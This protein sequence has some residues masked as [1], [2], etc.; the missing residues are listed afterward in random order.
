[1][2][3]EPPFRGHRVRLLAD[4]DWFTPAPGMGLLVYGEGICG[5]WREGTYRGRCIET[6]V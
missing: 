6:L 1:M 5:S 3:R 4:S 2:F